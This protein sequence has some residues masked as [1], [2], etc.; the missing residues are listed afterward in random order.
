M[1]KLQNIINENIEW[2][3]NNDPMLEYESN[4]EELWN[5]FKLWCIPNCKENFEDMDE[6]IIEE[7]V[8]ASYDTWRNWNF[9]N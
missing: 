8:N 9:A 1:E 5:G 4:T 6:S 7:A 3:W 2:F